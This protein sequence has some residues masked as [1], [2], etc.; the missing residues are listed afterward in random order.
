[1]VARVGTFAF[2]GIEAQEIDVQCQLSSGMVN[3]FVVGLADKA[4]SESRERIRAVFASLGL[5]FPAKK[6]IV[7][8]SP[9]DI[10]K[11][12]S[13]FDLPIILSVLTAMKLLPQEQIENYFTMGELSLDGRIVPVSGVLPAA[14]AASSLGK[15]FICP[16]DNAHEAAWADSELEILPANHV[17]DI[18]NHFKGSVQI[19]KPQFENHIEEP[20]YPDFKDVKGQELAK[21]AAEVAAAG[22][23]NMLMV[24]PPGSGKSM[25]ASRI[26]GIMPPLTSKEILETSMVYSIS[27]SLKEGKL[28]TSRPY[29]APHHN[30]SMPALIGGGTKAKPGEISLAHNGILFLDEFPEFPRQVLDSLRQPLETADVTISRVKSHVTYPANFQLIAAMNP[31]KCGY[32]DD[33]SR[34]CNK[35]PLCGNDYQMKLSG[36]LL[37][38][39]D[40]HIEVPAQSPLEAF[41]EKQSETSAQIKQRVLLASEIQ[42]QRFANCNYNTNSEIEG[43]DLNKFCIL[44]DDAKAIFEKGVVS[45]KLSMR[46]HARVLRV[47]RTIADLDNSDI[48]N[49]NQM[50]EA[51]SYRQINYGK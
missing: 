41:A 40:I 15:G 30:A 42:K 47:A 1:M 19:S 11:E 38:R 35:A 50:A 48:I 29:R 10:N 49:K 34:A 17:L 45:L 28:V 13:H 7:N 24:G 20:N 26:A 25:I 6:V 46:G 43:E 27:G 32:L 21:R 18:L 9:A 14:I 4:V 51:L 36:P 22:G 44:N 8:L 39:I 23:H 5:S 12:G 31:C 16:K 37:D 2:N 3:F 33:A